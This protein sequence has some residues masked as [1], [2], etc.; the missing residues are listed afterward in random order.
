M[1]H[2]WTIGLATGL[3]T[4][5]TLATLS[6][7]SRADFFDNPFGDTAAGPF[8]IAEEGEAFF[9]IPAFEVVDAPEVRADPE[10]LDEHLAEVFAALPQPLPALVFAEG[11]ETE[12]LRLD[13]ETVLVDEGAFVVFVDLAE[14]V[15]RSEGVAE[16][17][18]IRGVEPPE[19][20]GREPFVV[21]ESRDGEPLSGS[22]VIRLRDDSGQTVGRRLVIEVVSPEEKDARTS[23]RPDQRTSAGGC[24]TCKDGYVDPNDPSACVT[25]QGAARLK[26]LVSGV[27]GVPTY[28]DTYRKGGQPQCVCPSNALG[29]EDASGNVVVCQEVCAPDEVWLSND[30]QCVNARFFG[31]DGHMLDSD[32]DGLSDWKESLLG[33]D[34]NRADTDGDGLDDM[35]EYIAHTS[36]TNADTDGDQLV[37]GDEVKAGT[38]PHKPDTD[39]DCLPDGLELTYGTDPLDTDTDG[40]TLSD[41]SEVLAACS[42]MSQ[43]SFRYSSPTMVDTDGDGLLDPFERQYGTDPQNRDT[44]GDRI[45]DATE[46]RYFLNALHDGPGDQDNDQ[47]PDNDADSDGI[48]DWVELNLRHSNPASSDSDGD[49]LSDKVEDNGS[50][51]YA[52]GRAC[53][54]DLNNWDS[55]GDGLADGDEVNIYHTAPCLADTDGDGLND[56]REVIEL[57]T[58]PDAKDSDGDGWNDWFE[59][60]LAGTN[61]N[62]KDTDGDGVN[63]P[64]DPNPLKHASE[65]DS[66]G[67]GLDDADEVRRGTKPGTA[68]TDGDGLSDGREV[69][70]TRT[71]P[72][73]KDTDGDG[74]DDGWELDR[75]L[76]AREWDSDGDGYSDRDEIQID[77]LERAKRREQE[78]DISKQPRGSKKYGA[79]A[80]TLGYKTYRGAA[81]PNGLASVKHTYVGQ[82]QIGDCWLLSALASVAKYGPQHINNLIEDHHDGT[83]TVTLFTDDSGGTKKIKVDSKFVWNSTKNWLQYGKIPT[84]S[85]QRNINGKVVT[86]TVR[87]LWPA[88]LEKAAAVYYGNSY[89]S[90]DGGFWG[91]MARLTGVSTWWTFALPH[92]S[93]KAAF[94]KQLSVSKTQRMALAFSTS[95]LGKKKAQ[96]TTCQGVSTNHM[97]AYIGET[98]YDAA[99]GV[100]RYRLYDPH[101]KGY[102]MTLEELTSCFTGSI[103]AKR[104]LW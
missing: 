66:D 19:R 3:A 11:A 70:V 42:G 8:V 27:T 29:Y 2:V 104:S 82:N 90:L 73:L 24:V 61:P 62:E 46:I 89:N 23:C 71:D 55:D 80:Q 76:S 4:L 67:D 52:P 56:K 32:G 48:T 39:G 93:K 38:D 85:V 98:T 37:D 44:D 102:L 50:I 35:A 92:G 30:R 17:E 18:I 22:F 81:F 7:P 36:L 78:I 43:A 59:V 57:G 54:T 94:A 41:G 1:R 31:A 84:E 49:G 103:L 65:T 20:F 60:S 21:L 25:C 45:D 10:V 100:T 58:N 53:T 97:V 87:V 14:A 6:A 88:L 9:G 86:D 26:W 68:D 34:P 13:D 63:D 79:G 33:S 16:V 96:S 74:L 51:V 69:Y 40:D 5:T 72:T 83:Y 15:E 64:Q 91:G 75:G 101:Q 28:Y 47:R 99:A 95:G 77:G 12:P